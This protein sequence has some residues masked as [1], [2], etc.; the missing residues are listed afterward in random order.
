MNKVIVLVDPVIQNAYLWKRVI[1]WERINTTFPLFGI[2]LPLRVKKKTSL[3]ERNSKPVI[4]LFD[5]MM[6][7]YTYERA[8]LYK[9]RKYHYNISMFTSECFM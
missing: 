8:S 7:T 5:V 4:F 3:I 1:K 9:P 2:I 6:L